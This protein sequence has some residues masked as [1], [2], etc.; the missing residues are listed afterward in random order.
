MIWDL[1]LLAAILIIAL[2]N[3]FLIWHLYQVKSRTIEIKVEIDESGEIY[4]S[5]GCCSPE[6]S[7]SKD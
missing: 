6:D 3:I 5:D 4:C 1:F 7:I 2:I